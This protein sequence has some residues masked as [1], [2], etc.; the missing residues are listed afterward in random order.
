MQYPKFRQFGEGDFAMDGDQIIVD[1]DGEIDGKAF[2]NNS[3]KG[4]LIQL[5]N[6]TFIRDFEI[7]VMGMGAGDKK[8]FDVDFA[9]DFHIK[10]L[11]GK[12]VHF[13]VTL[14]TGAKKELPDIDEEFLKNVGAASVEDLNLKL[15]QHVDLAMAQAKKNGLKTALIDKLLES[16]TISVPDWMISA[17]A[18]S[19]AQKY[20]VDFDKA[21]ESVKMSF[22]NESDKALK[23]ALIFDKIRE[24]EVETVL[25]DEEIHKV[26]Q[27]HM[28]QI[29]PDVQMEMQ[30]QSNSGM[31]Q[32][33]YSEIQDEQVFEWLFR[34]STIVEPIE[35]NSSSEQPVESK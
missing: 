4:V 25:S 8:E 10:H 17:N 11:A 28:H 22:I 1:Y 31:L 2:E 33:M 27:Q 7:N 14:T 26:I 35:P 34:H 32:K 16:N 9:E 30:K 15:K 6:G 23:I 20:G 18:K 5:G 19:M 21:E 12:K 3:A 24:K 13:K 29:P